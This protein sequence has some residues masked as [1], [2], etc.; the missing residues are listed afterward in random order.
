MEWILFTGQPG[1]GKTTAVKK[2]VAHLRKVLPPCINLS[3]FYTDEVLKKGK[4]VGFDV[5]T[6]DGNRGVLS[7]ADVRRNG[8]MVGRYSVDVD[9]FEKLA[10]PT[11][12]LRKNTIYVLDEVGRM[13]LKSEKFKSAVKVLLSSNVKLVGA[14]TAPIYGHRVEFCDEIAAR[15]GVE[16]FKILKGTRDEVTDKVTTRILSAWGAR[17]QEAN[18]F[19]KPVLELYYK[20]TADIKGLVEHAVLPFASSIGLGGVIITFK[21]EKDA[22][23]N[24]KACK[25]LKT[26]LPSSVDI[27]AV[28]SSKFVKQNIAESAKRLAA[29]ASDLKVNGATSILVVSGTGKKKVSNSMTIIRDDALGGSAGPWGVAFNPY[30]GCSLDPK[31]ETRD[32]RRRE[33]LDRLRAKLNSHRG[34]SSVWLQFGVDVEALERGLSDL[35]AILKECNKEDAKIYGS[36]FV[37]TKSWV[38]KMKFRTWSGVFLGT[39]TSGEG[40]YFDGGAAKLTR[41]IL[42]IYSTYGI[43][44]VVESSVR[45]CRDVEAC[46][47]MFEQLGVERQAKRKR[48]K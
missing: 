41:A 44:P 5:V 17:H 12:A 32:A 34:V 20:S 36:I 21:S 19:E 24:S 28:W 48:V 40:G 18:K 33:E 16:V 23:E 9:S 29:Y 6:L 46:A 35:S 1:V 45:T 15:R 31:A 43:I 3:G 4:R 2:V 26:L 42:N 8:C 13:E 25:I 14:L 47:H 30:I 22:Q 38:A 39:K 10:L 7:R 37:P 27:H 11:L